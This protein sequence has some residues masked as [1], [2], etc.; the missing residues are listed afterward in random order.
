MAQ[1]CAV[2]HMADDD[3]E[4]LPP[5]AESAV[6]DDDE[7]PPDVLS[8]EGSGSDVCSPCPA[9]RSKC[10]C[11]NRCYEKVSLQAVRDSREQ[12]LILSR[13][14]RARLVIAAVS[15]QVCDRR[16]K[17]KPRYRQRTFQGVP[18]CR[19]L[20]EY[21]H[22]VGHAGVEMAKKCLQMGA[23]GPP[24]RL[25]WL[26]AEKSKF[27]DA[28]TWFLDLYQSLGEPLAEVDPSFLDAEGCVPI[29]DADHLLWSLRIAINNGQYA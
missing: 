10:A 20:W 21:A 3:G 24:E 29:D 8:E 1:K 14:D 7:L 27:N 25:P 15:G 4:S 9:L 11:Q 6:S 26:P 13:K 19:R 17:V 5:S 22:A 2:K 12:L 23:G 18:V 16:G 28:D